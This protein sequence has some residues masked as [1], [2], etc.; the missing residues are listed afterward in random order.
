MFTTRSKLAVIAAVLI[1]LVSCDSSKQR[2][3]YETHAEALLQES[4]TDHTPDS[5]AAQ[6]L[7][8]L[9][10]SDLSPH[11]CGQAELDIP[12]GQIPEDYFIEGGTALVYTKATGALFFSIV[13][14]FESF[15]VD[16]DISIEDGDGSLNLLV[17]LAPAR[18]PGNTQNN[19]RYL[20]LPPGYI[21]TGDQL[22]L[23][24]EGKFRLTVYSEVFPEGAITQ[25]IRNPVDCDGL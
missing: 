9:Q 8:E 4:S 10:N 22:T 21:L 20:T 7:P 14:W 1:S 2:S 19:L 6:S 23:L 13:G 24:K 17:S 11:L 3:S 25:I 15:S 18:Y 12:V 16:A 5:S